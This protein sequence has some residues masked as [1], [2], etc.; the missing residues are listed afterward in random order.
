MRGPGTGAY[1][2]ATARDPG[3]T[4]A[5]IARPRIDQNPLSWLLPGANLGPPEA[6]PFG[7]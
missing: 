5:R 6:Y 2:R 1:S 7:P 3:G 4:G